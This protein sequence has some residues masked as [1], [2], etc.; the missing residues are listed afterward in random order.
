VSDRQVSAL[1]ADV[2]QV[3]LIGAGVSLQPPAPL[4]VRCMQLVEVQEYVV[5][6][7]VLLEQASPQVQA[8]PSSQTVLVRHCH[9]PPAL[10]QYQAWPPQLTVWHGVWLDVLHSR[11]VP[12]PQVPL[13]RLGPQSWQVLPTVRKLP[14][15]QESV[16]AHDPALVPQPA[17]ELH[18]AVQH[19]LVAPTEQAVEDGEHEHESQPPAPSQ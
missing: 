16:P 11:V 9:V 6:R 19:W 4:Q 13:A 12:P 15:A 2:P 14:V 7:H 3:V 1:Q 5:P 8:S 18:V 17:P 10:V